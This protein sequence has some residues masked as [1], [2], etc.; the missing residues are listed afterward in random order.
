[1]GMVT[2]FS[3]TDKIKALTSEP[4]LVEA[5]MKFR[6]NSITLFVFVGIDRSEDGLNGWSDKLYRLEVDI[7]YFPP[8]RT[9]VGPICLP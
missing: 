2:L 1:M 8:D 9:E 7:A 4:C 5:A 3:Y 6:L